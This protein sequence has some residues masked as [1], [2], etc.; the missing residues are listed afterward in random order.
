MNAHFYTVR[1]VHESLLK[2]FHQYLRAQYHIWD[3]SLINE[4]DRIIGQIGN[5]FQEPRLE[6]TPQYVAGRPYADLSVPAVV[7]SVLASAAE[8]QSTGIPRIAYSHQCLAVEKFIGEAR[9]LIVA[10]GTGSG[11]T[12]SFLMPIISSVALECAHRPASWALPGMRALLLYPMNAL[13]N[14]QLARLRR[15][16]GNRELCD[17]IRGNTTRGPRFG[18]YTSRTPYPGQRMPEKDKQRVEEEIRKLYFDG[19]TD[20]FRNRLQSEG[21][22]PAKNLEQFVQNGFKTSSD[23]TELFTRHEIQ[24]TCPDLLV[25]NYSMLEY[26]M[27]RPLEANV[28]DQTAQWLSSSTDNILTVV[29]DEA[30][31]YRGSGGAEVAYLLRRLQSR[32]GVQRDRIRYILTSA[33]LGSSEDAKIEIKKFAANLTG[34][35]VEQFEL[36]GSELEPRT[37]CAPASAKEQA[38]L[39][40]FDASKIQS[41]IDIDA[42]AA[43]LNKLASCIGAESRDNL[44]SERTSGSSPLIF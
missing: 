30:H 29:L 36:I 27:L 12:E 31:M 28:F 8:I 7:R 25:T 3:E 23:D 2:T 16:L 10:T 24:E 32:L 35:K 42:A 5:T 22:W 11:K 41:V 40:A 17:V 20:D 21:K 38:C 4:R 1:S 6:A 44:N 39:A 18:M 43:D 15:L 37:G 14:D 34:G 33:S 13:V 9:D 19:M 26:M